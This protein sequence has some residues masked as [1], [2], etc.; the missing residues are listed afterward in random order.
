[1]MACPVTEPTYN[2][3]EDMCTVTTARLNVEMIIPATE[4]TEESDQCCIEGA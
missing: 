3:L 1:M 4:M 2:F